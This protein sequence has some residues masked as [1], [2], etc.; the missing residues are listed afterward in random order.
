MQA[1]EL[2]EIAKR[3]ARRAVGLCEADRDDLA[4][5]A[6]VHLVNLLDRLDTSRSEAEQRAF[7]RR[8]ARNNI[9]TALRKQVRTRVDPTDPSDIEVADDLA[10]P[11]KIM[12][13]KQVQSVIAQ[14]LLKAYKSLTP[15]QRAHMRVSLGWEEPV[16]DDG[17][18]KGARAMIAYRVRERVRQILREERLDAVDAETLLGMVR[19]L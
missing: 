1:A 8:C 4:Q 3:E 17:R 7:M 12:E 14:V 9:L 6:A 13:A 5:D 18:T 2:L 10:T 15:D 16:E 19:G 11:E